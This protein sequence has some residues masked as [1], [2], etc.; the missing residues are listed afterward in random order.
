LATSPAAVTLTHEAQKE[1]SRLSIWRQQFIGLPLLYYI[2][3][4][5]KNIVIT[6]IECILVIEHA[7]M[8]CFRTM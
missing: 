8:K 5:N 2:F 3:E 1:K 4:F 7:C 6:V